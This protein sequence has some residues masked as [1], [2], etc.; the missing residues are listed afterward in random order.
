VGSSY[1][2]RILFQLELIGLSRLGTSALK[3]MA[4][5]IPGYRALRDEHNTLIPGASSDFHA[6][7]D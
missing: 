5:A 3:T 1:S 2:T 6:Y 7:D 4:A